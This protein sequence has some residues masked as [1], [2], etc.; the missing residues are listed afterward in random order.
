MTWR[1]LPLPPAIAAM[2][3]LLLEAVSR[4]VR[5]AVHG[6][7]NGEMR[8]TRRIVTRI[9]AIL[10]HVIFLL[11]V[12]VEVKARAAALVRHPVFAAGEAQD[13]GLRGVGHP[14]SLDPGLGLRPPQDD[15]R[16]S[17][18]NLQRKLAGIRAAAG[19]DLWFTVPTSSRHPEAAERHS[20][21]MDGRLRTLNA[22]ATLRLQGD[23]GWSENTVARK[24]AGI[25]AALANPLRY[26]KRIARALNST[27]CLILPPKIP[28]TI[29]KTDER[30]FWDE[31]LSA[32]E[33]ARFAY[34]QYWAKRR[35]TS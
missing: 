22:S 34:H 27:R 13:P 32:A 31:R 3:A 29:P 26:A 4:G 24:L 15:G 14:K 11:A 2:I 25:R 17:E 1:D 21:S 28:R 30:E 18:K 8:R 35:D 9:T 33:E 5:M 19:F 16:C 7:A 10:R 20:G 6:L 23:G 12:R